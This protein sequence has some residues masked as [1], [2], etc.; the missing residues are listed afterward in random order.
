MVPAVLT[1]VIGSKGRWPLSESS[2][3]EFYTYS[4]ISKSWSKSNQAIFELLNSQDF[5]NEKYIEA[6]LD[7]VKKFTHDSRI[8]RNRSCVHLTTASK[9]DKIVDVNKEFIIERDKVE[10]VL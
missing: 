5:P 7:T 6:L 8:F 4:E 9:A 10:I 3:F 1:G 2:E